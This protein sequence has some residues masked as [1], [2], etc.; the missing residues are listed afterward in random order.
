MHEVQCLGLQP[1]LVG[2][3]GGRPRDARGDARRRVRGQKSGP[4]PR[5]RYSGFVPSASPGRPSGTRGPTYVRTSVL[6]PRRR[7][8]SPP[9]WIEAVLGDPMHGGD[10]VVS[11]DL[12][13]GDR[14]S[15]FGLTW[16][17]F[18]TGDPGTD[19]RG[20]ARRLPP[21]V[22]ER[23]SLVEGVLPLPM[24]R[25]SGRGAWSGATGSVII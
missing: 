18:G 25:P 1:H 10:H 13:E 16:S 15:A 3:R 21:S 11:R 9:R 20:D 24:P 6:E 22:L 5:S 23:S 19:A 7:S 4:L 12:G 17:A 14:S 8:S 2:L